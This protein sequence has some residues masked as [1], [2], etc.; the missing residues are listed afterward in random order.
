MWWLV[1]GSSTC[2][3]SAF[4]PLYDCF[5]LSG[6]RKDGLL[7]SVKLARKDKEGKWWPLCIS[8][9]THQANHTC[10]GTVNAEFQGRLCVTRQDRISWWPSS[11]ERCDS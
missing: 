5:G 2:A 7:D 11:I 1:Q 6:W 8:V 4:P 9:G 10:V 3:P